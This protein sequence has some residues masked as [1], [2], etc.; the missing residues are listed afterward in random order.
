MNSRRKMR[1]YVALNTENFEQ[2]LHS[3]AEGSEQLEPNIDTLCGRARATA[4]SLRDD[5]M[6]YFIDEEEI[7]PRPEKEVIHSSYPPKHP[8]A[9]R[10]ITI[11][12]ERPVCH[13]ED[14][15]EAHARYVEN[16]QFFFEK[17]DQAH[18]AFLE[19]IEA[20]Q[21]AR[22]EKAFKALTNAFQ[23]LEYSI[24]EELTMLYSVAEFE[25]ALLLKMREEDDDPDEIEWMTI[26][27]HEDEEAPD[28]YAEDANI[29]GERG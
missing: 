5:A 21:E 19:A 9:G 3:I 22:D 27:P 28:D 15:H 2:L 11:V 26:D 13:R 24:E 10:P 14:S 12:I 29:I 17:M 6:K 16:Y 18:I 1:G 23:H 25:P 20:L 4:A 7:Q 8:L